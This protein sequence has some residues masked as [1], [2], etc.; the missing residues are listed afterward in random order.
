MGP[1]FHQ[2]HPRC[3]GSLIPT[4]LQPLGYGKP[5]PFFY[6]NSK[7]EL[8]RFQD[9]FGDYFIPNSKKFSGFVVVL[10]PR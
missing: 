2:L 8:F 6:I 9:N 4:A 7:T 10:R 5:L 1:A 3:I